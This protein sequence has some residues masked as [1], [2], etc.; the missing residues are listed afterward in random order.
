[1]KQ[2]RQFALLWAALCIV[3]GAFA[4]AAIAKPAL[5]SGKSPQSK[6]HAKGKKKGGAAGAL[7]RGFGTGGKVTVAFPAEN[8]GS[9]APKY[10]LPFEF[11]PGHL[12]MAKSPGGEVVVAGPTKIVRYLPSG[13][14]DPT[15]G[16]N[17]TVAVPRPGAVFVLASVAVD[18]E[19][20]VVLAGQSRP[21]PSNSAP[22]PLLSSATV[23]R[24]NVNGTPD[25]SFGTD[26]I[27]V[28]NFGIHAPTAPGGPYLGSSV[29]IRDVVI[30]AENRPVLSGA[31]VK[32][33]GTGHGSA[34]TVGFV[35]RLTEAGA[36]DTSFG[37][38]G[39][40]PIDS[41]EALG[42]ILPTARGYLS[43]AESETKPY[44]SLA[45]L[46]ENGNLDTSFASFG[47]RAISVG[48][49]QSLAISPGGKILI[50]GRPERYRHYRNKRVKD[51]D[52]GK[53]KTEKVRYYVNEQVVQRLLPNGAGD[54]GFGQSGTIAYNDPTNGSYAAVAADAGE[55]L[56][57]AGRIGPSSKKRSGAHRTSFLLSR[58]KAS[59]NPDR[60]FGKAG[61]VVTGFGG[62]SSSFAT[63][64]AV[65]NKGRILVGGGIESAQFASGGGFAIARYLPGK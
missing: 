15:F 41:L 12:Q 62:R 46:G 40:R 19:G 33:V 48:A 11:T 13:K 43:L 28:S 10:E 30:D 65:D 18:S 38:G 45:G 35:A 34:A 60:G 56:Y 3:L 25:T 53:W 51:E 49:P 9:T 54:P 27:V 7:D 58:A 50:L 29:G 24:F 22:D 14:P 17:G 57:L 20:R 2:V 1:M 42:Q 39:L 64:V 44:W 47:F 37:E 31:Y 63:Q 26:G 21:L 23:M 52:T 59:G 61:T 32:A 55:R 36:L 5:K 4:G 16:R 6:A 8:S